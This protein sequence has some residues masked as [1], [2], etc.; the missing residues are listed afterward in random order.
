MGRKNS[1]D[2]PLAEVKLDSA[3]LALKIR[4]QFAEK[5]KAGQDFGKTFI[6]NSVTLPTR[7]R[8]DIMRAIAR[9]YTNET[10][11]FF[12]SSYSSRP[13]MHTRPKDKSQRSNAYTFSDSISRYGADLISAELGD[14]YRR[15]GMSFKGQLQQNFVVLHDGGE[16]EEGRNASGY[17]GGA[18]NVQ[19]KR[20][21]RWVRK[22]GGP[23]KKTKN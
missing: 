17:S 16:G 4:K 2:I 3:E 12:V 8:V 15:A 22:V 19:R 21:G 7:V 9:K 10:T 11:E 14:A 5:K 6:T 18:S 20:P 1:Q 13:I 23:V